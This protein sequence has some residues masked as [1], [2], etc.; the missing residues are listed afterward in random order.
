MGNKKAGVREK[1]IPVFW[2][3]FAD[4]FV[5]RNL[6][7]CVAGVSPLRRR[8]G[9]FAV[10]PLTPSHCTPMFLEWYCSYCIVSVPFRSVYKELHADR[11]TGC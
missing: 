10:A 5:I 1:R 4:D 8:Q 3:C 7:F 6:F 2:F 11:E 9:G